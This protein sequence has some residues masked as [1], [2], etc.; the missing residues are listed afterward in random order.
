MAE[1]GAVT[2]QYSSAMGCLTAIWREEGLRG[3]YRGQVP[4]LL[5][6]VPAISIG[7]GV[8]ELTR[9]LLEDT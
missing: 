1:S 4:S 9:N 2:A 5:K 3:L 7:Y 8:F 6:T